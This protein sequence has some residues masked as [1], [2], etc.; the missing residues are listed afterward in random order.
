M[1]VQISVRSSKVSPK[2]LAQVVASRKLNSPAS[3]SKYRASRA[4]LRS[5]ARSTASA[6][7]IT[8]LAH[9]FTAT[10]NLDSELTRSWSPGRRYQ[11]L[12]RESGLRFGCVFSKTLRV[13]MPVSEA[14][15]MSPK[16]VVTDTG[17]ESTIREGS[18]ALKANISP[19]SGQYRSTPIRRLQTRES[20]RQKV[21]IGISP[22]AVL[23]STSAS[24]ARSPAGR[25][26]AGQVRVSSS[27]RDWLNR[28][29]TGEHEDSRTRAGSS[30]ESKGRE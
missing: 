18:P 23:V 26:R 29:C 9:R 7:T 3:E 8:D 25:K 19:Y 13:V 24:E 15:L 21:S 11:A 17:P 30:S 22:S 6:S 14:W 27:K 12:L 10:R 16:D 5:M 1:A 2:C 28:L 4:I 20:A